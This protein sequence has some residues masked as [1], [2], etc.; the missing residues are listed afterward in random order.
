MPSWFDKK[1]MLA[2]GLGL[3]GASFGFFIGPPLIILLPDMYGIRGMFIMLAGIWIH[4]LVVGI[5]Q[6]PCPS[7]NNVMQTPGSRSNTLIKSLS[8]TADEIIILSSTAI[9]RAERTNVNEKNDCKDDGNIC[10][11]NSHCSEIHEEQCNICEVNSHCSEIYEEQCNSNVE[12]T[13]NCQTEKSPRNT[14]YFT[15]LKQPR[16]LHAY[17]ILFLGVFGAFGKKLITLFTKK[18]VDLK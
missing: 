1:L 4:T 12:S 10:E 17:M 8:H 15:L 14:S 7:G 5:I 16:V 2:S 18:K 13:F 6:R 9:G 11:V 3:S